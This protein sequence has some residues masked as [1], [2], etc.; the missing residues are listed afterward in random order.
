MKKY[1]QYTKEELLNIIKD[2]N[3]TKSK[4]NGQVYYYKKS[5]EYY[6]K[7]QQKYYD[8][9]KELEEINNGK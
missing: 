2:K 7:A 3:R 4:L 1:Q 8:K 9:L 6:K 5:K